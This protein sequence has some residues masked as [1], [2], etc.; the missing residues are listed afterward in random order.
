M[1]EETKEK[2]PPQPDAFPKKGSSASGT[3]FAYTVEARYAYP[4]PKVICGMMLDLR[5]RSVQFDPSPIGV[6]TQHR[7]CPWGGGFPHLMT[8]PAAQALRWWFLAQAKSVFDHLC[9]ETRLVK[10]EVTYQISEKAIA[11]AAEIDGGDEREAFRQPPPLPKA[12]EA[13]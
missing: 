1:S 4:E 3:E 10:H 11:A 12:V 6:P 5:W 13:A 8:Y 9:V 7:Y 2:Y